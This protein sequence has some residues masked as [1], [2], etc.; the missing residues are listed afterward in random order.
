M[1]RR[2]TYGM[3]ARNYRPVYGNKLKESDKVETL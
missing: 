3:E 1:K 2:V